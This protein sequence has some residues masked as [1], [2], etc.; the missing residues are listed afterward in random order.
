VD[1]PGLERVAG[2]WGH[3]P[4]P[5]GTVRAICSKGRLLPTL[6]QRIE[7]AGYRLGTAMLAAAPEA[8]LYRAVG[9]IANHTVARFGRRAHIT[10]VNLQ[11]AFPEKSEAERREIARR[12]FVDLL[13]AGVDLARVRSYSREELV[14]RVEFHGREHIE[15]TTASGRGCLILIPHLG[16]LELALRAAP[17]HGLP[18]CVMTKPAS[19]PLIDDDLNGQ[20]ERGGAQVLAH[21]GVL[22]EALEA[23]REQRVLVISNDQYE[24]RGRA[25]EVP[26]F[27]VRVPTG[28]GLASLSL[29]TGVPVVPFYIA[30]RDFRH[31]R[32]ICLPPI[33]PVRTR[34][35]R[36][37]VKNMTTRYN[38]AIEG[39]I[40]EHPEQY[41]WSHKRFRNLPKIPED[42]YER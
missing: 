7:Y 12:S 8:A 26:F 11:I 33:A 15:K 41:L 16:S 5:R 42:V 17:A 4:A 22:A 18:I 6:T 20:R 2:R 38:E 25:V 35:F 32:M 28:R 23:L 19:N 27:G 36:R 34:N 10:R 29:R 14:E 39:I 31:S 13:W 21:R 37:D 1:G 24:R 40:R 30:R 3:A 9:A